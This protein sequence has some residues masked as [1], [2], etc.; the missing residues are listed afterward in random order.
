M[1]DFG[2]VTFQHDFLSDSLTGA[3]AQYLFN[4]ELVRAVESRKRNGGALFM[5]T[6]RVIAPNK[7][8]KKGSPAHLKQINE[9]EKKLVQASQIIHRIAPLVSFSAVH[10][11]LEIRAKVSATSAVR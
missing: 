7:K 8:L 5:I 9:Y 3:Q 4:R 1:F 11:L 6:V 10:N 2:K